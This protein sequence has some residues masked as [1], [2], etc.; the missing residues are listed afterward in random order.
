MTSTNV[1]HTVID[2]A[3]RLMHPIMPFLTEEL[4]QRL[5]RQQNDE[6]PSICVAPY[7]TL[8]EVRWCSIVAAHGGT[9]KTC[10][11]RLFVNN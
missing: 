9:L 8:Q 6:C 5:P 3:L 7:P 11:G 1:L 10:S 4:F 2:G